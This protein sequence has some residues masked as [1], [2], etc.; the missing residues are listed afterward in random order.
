MREPS[1]T[2]QQ[3]Y[4]ISGG[5]RKV[6]ARLIAEIRVNCSRIS[7]ITVRSAILEAIKYP[8]RQEPAAR[9]GSAKEKT[10]KERAALLSPS[11]LAAIKSEPQKRI[12][13]A[14]ML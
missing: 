14:V 7:P 6:R 12:D 5:M 13:D 2:A 4:S 11:Q 3:A 1:T 8:L 10:F 9:K